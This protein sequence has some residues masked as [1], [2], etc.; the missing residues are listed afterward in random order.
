[1]TVTYQVGGGG[2]LDVDFWLT[3]P[4]N[5]ELYSQRKK[6]TGTYSFT[7]EKESVHRSL[8]ICTHL[9]A[10][11]SG[12]YDYC[13]SN[14]MSTVAGKTVSFNVHGVLYVDDDGTELSRCSHCRATV[15]QRSNR[16]HGT[17][18]KGDP[19]ARIGARS[20]QG[21]ARIHCRPRAFAPRQLAT[22][23]LRYTEDHRLTM[24]CSC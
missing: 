1:M 23:L 21:R 20:R 15:T 19:G 2:H 11:P 5:M 17:N 12:R 18:R 24:L 22:G 16:A 13:F 9:T 4:N 6:D 14:A 3:D 8:C 7:A 10:I